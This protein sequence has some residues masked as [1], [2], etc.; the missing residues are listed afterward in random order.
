MMSLYMYAPKAEGT[1]LISLR[2]S[3]SMGL[4]ITF[5]PLPPS[6]A[7]DDGSVRPFRSIFE[8]YDIAKEE[9]QELD[10]T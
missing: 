10:L 3:G 1:D 8:E 2:P 7:F 6:A 9:L 5:A 4:Y